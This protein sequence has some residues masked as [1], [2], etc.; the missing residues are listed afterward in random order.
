LPPAAQVPGYDFLTDPDQTSTLAAMMGATSTPETTTASVAAQP[1]AT[2]RL[3]SASSPGQVL[4]DARVPAAQN[5][6]PE[7]DT[8]GPSNALEP[9]VGF[10]KAEEKPTP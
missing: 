7:T 3:G 1:E 9:A 6:G 10:E 5:I 2:Q 4:A 8:A